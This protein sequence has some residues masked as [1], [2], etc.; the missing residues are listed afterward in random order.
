MRGYSPQLATIH[1]TGFADLARDAARHLR[2]LAPG[3]KRVLDLG[4]GAG[5]LAAALPGIQVWGIDLSQE[6][7][8]MAQA[9]VPSGT[10]VQGS[11]HD[12]EFPTAD[13][14]VMCGEVVNYMFDAKAADGLEALLRRIHDVLPPGGVLLFDVAMPG[15]ADPPTSGRIEGN[16]WSVEHAAHED[17]PLLVRDIVSHVQDTVRE[18]HRL[19]LFEATDVEAALLAAG[20]RLQWR[21]GYS[22]VP[23]GQGWAVIEAVA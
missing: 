18:Q 10:F 6:F 17:G 14:V 5:D 20:F 11:I 21:P 8:E 2:M 3:A 22:G 23:L 15:R 1:A 16:G 13:A 9:K 4:C 19:R 12:S 7:V